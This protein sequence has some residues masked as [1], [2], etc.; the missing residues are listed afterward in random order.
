LPSR[1][2]ASPYVTLIAS[3]SLFH[4]KVSDAGGERRARN[5][6][7]LPGNFPGGRTTQTTPRQRWR[8]WSSAP[9]DVVLLVVGLTAA[10]RYL[11]AW[12]GIRLSV[13]GRAGAT[14]T[15]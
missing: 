8:W 9:E 15:A 10:Y 13:E 7:P 3:E 5:R 6:T 12:R 2:R 1:Y 14:R 4:R 11:P